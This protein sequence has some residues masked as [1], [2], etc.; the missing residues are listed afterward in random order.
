MQLNLYNYKYYNI[1]Y[2]NLIRLPR[3]QNE[4]QVMRRHPS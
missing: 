4:M 3:L 1:V 2:N